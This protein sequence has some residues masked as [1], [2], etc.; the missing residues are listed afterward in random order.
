MCVVSHAS[1]GAHVSQHIRC[2]SA[3]EPNDD[4]SWQKPVLFNKRVMDWGVTF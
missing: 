4:C 3:L 2:P 1:I